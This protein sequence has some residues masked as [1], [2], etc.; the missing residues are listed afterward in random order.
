[1]RT[2]R[3]SPIPTRE[4]HI[5]QPLR[6][7]IEQIA[8]QCSLECCGI[9]ACSVSA[10]LLKLWSDSVGKAKTRSAI[11]QAL[12]IVRLCDDSTEPLSCELLSYRELCTPAAE[13][14]TERGGLERVQ[15]EGRR[16]LRDFFASLAEALRAYA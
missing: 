3:H 11:G 16:R 8:T 13:G 15:D 2:R 5:E 1:M 12:E 9:D 14:E 6:T 10:W 7:C 4:I